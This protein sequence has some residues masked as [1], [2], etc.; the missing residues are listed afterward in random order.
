MKT[1]DDAPFSLFG[2]GPNGVPG[3][4]ARAFDDGGDKLIAAHIEHFVRKHGKA[5]DEIRALSLLQAEHAG[6]PPHILRALA[7]SLDLISFKTGP[8]PPASL[9]EAI[10][11][12]PKVKK[13]RE[14]TEMAARHS[15]ALALTVVHDH[16]DRVVDALEDLVGRVAAGKLVLSDKALSMASGTRWAIADGALVETGTRPII[17]RSTLASWRKVPE[18]S[19]IVAE[20]GGRIAMHSCGASFTERAIREMAL[21]APVDDLLGMVDQVPTVWSA[22]PAAQAAARAAFEKAMQRK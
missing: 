10:G 19:H 15:Y 1:R 11:L 5:T 16:P 3:R 6:T 8:L 12:P 21:K 13:F 18:F 2:M 22:T 20:V 17:S 14:F 7:Y 9:R 4:F